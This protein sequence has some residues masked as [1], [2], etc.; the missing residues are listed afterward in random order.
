MNTAAEA[1]LAGI[2]QIRTDME[3]FMPVA[4]IRIMESPYCT[5]KV[6]PKKVHKVRRWM[7][8][9]Y[10]YR[11]QKKW[12]KRWGYVDEPTAYMLPAQRL[13]FNGPAESVVVMHPILA[14]QLREHMRK[15]SR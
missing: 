7:D 6:G 2:N 10:H 15:E 11:I 4:P 3:R 5:R 9:Q 14:A 13:T 12:I 8:D 1:I